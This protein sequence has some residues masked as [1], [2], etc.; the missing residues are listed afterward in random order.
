MHTITNC[1]LV[2]VVPMDEK[3]NHCVLHRTGHVLSC[4]VLAVVSCCQCNNGEEIHRL[5]V[6]GTS[7]A[8]SVFYGRPLVGETRT[9]HIDLSVMSY[10]GIDLDTSRL[11]GG[12]FVSSVNPL[13]AAAY[14]GVAVGDQLHEVHPNPV[15]QCSKIAPS[16]NHLSFAVNGELI[17]TVPT[18]SL[19]L[20]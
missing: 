10:L 3:C 18:S 4:T 17:G 20:K 13:S 6:N 8:S 2:R 12:L 11:S 15:T 19:S 5:D 1:W 14:Q 16:V 7:I 9:V